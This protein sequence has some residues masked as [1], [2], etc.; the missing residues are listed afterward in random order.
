MRDLVGEKFQAALRVRRKS[1]AKFKGLGM[2]RLAAQ[3]YKRLYEAGN[4]RLRTFA[5][6]AWAAR[7]R[8]T[9]I[10]ILLTELCNARCVHC[11]IWKNRGKE[12]SPSVDQWQQTL[13]DLR[14]WLG[15]VQVTFT[16]GEAL[17]KSYATDLVA[18]ASSLGLFVEH[19][20]HGYWDDQSK[21]ERLAL[22][23]PWRVTI[24]VDGVG[25]THTRIRG[26]EKFFEKTS[27]TIQTLQRVRK[28]KTLDYTIR[29]KTVIMHHNL[30]DVCEVARFAHQDGM[31][32]FYQP[33]EQNYNTP[34]DPRWFEHSENWP[35]DTAKAVATVERLIALKRQGLPIANSYAQLEVMIPYFRNPDAMRVATQ[36]HTAHDRRALCA[37]LTNLQ[38]Q[39]NGDVTVCSGIKPVGNIKTT[40][41][42]QIWELRP[43]VW[44][45][46]C[47]LTWRCSPAEKENLSLPIHS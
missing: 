8:P 25:E 12:D 22:A 9:T 32:V 13:R 28:E 21:I 44:E 1:A 39:A 14:R 47:C 31:D 4:Y 19:L 7:C 6:G 41:I 38:L 3:L 46:G 23:R 37:A 17:L 33:I 11:D 20:T 26:R 5:G 36:G 42:R 18:Y 45:E 34:E 29:L 27:T 15:P 16:G 43:R 24:S 2:S 35:Q 40:P 10:A 30:D